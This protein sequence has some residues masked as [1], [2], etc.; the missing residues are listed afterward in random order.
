MQES[1]I[2][3]AGRVLEEKQ[4]RRDEPMAAH[5]TFRI[6]GPADLFLEPRSDQVAP[7]L[8]ALRE[9]G[10]PLLVIGNGSDLLVGDRGI[11]GA[12]IQIGEHM[13]E[14]TVR[15]EEIKAQAG[16]LLTRVAGQARMAGLSGMEALAGIPGSLGGAVMMNA[17]AYGGSMADVVASVE[18][19][20]EDG[21]VR[22]FSSEE[23]HFSYRHSRI[24]EEGGIVLSA[25][26]RLSPGDREEIGALMEELTRRRREK[27]PLNMPSAGSRFKRPRGYFAGKLIQDAGLRGYRVGQAQVSEKHCGFV[28]NLGGAS[29]AEVRQLM[30]DVRAR[31]KEKFH[32]DLEP[33]VRFVGEF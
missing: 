17:G 31:V 7:L 20:T 8:A 33:E 16:A 27:Q 29:A 30:E 11:R 14:I 6:G 22:N 26:L 12:V 18:V 13:A 24:A 25:V 23:M 21:Q 3:A 15:E 19:L 1:W 10:A 2:E 32:V 9:A 28:V 5:T 4:I